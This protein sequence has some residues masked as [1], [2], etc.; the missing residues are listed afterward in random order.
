[1]CVFFVSN[2]LGVQKFSSFYSTVFLQNA[3]SFVVC[4]AVTQMYGIIK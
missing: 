3:F 4:L 2:F 1:M